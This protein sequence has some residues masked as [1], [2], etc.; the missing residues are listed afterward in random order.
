MA[1]AV[2]VQ[3]THGA[4]SVVRWATELAADRLL[5][6]SVMVPARGCPRRFSLLH[7]TWFEGSRRCNRYLSRFATLA[8]AAPLLQQVDG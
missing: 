4:S 8:P 5:V 2:S 7:V 3:R 6:F 1:T